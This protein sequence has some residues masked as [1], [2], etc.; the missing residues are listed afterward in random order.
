MKIRAVR[1]LA[2]FLLLAW[3]FPSHAHAGVWC[4]ALGGSNGCHGATDCVHSVSVDEVSTLTVN[5][6]YTTTCTNS[7]GQPTETTTV[8]TQ[9]KTATTSVTNRCNCV[10]TPSLGRTWGQILNEGECCSCFD[11]TC[12]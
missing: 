5:V 8:E 7:A 12:I 9:A 3:V 2:P 4:D 6:Y 1:W 10:L 11:L